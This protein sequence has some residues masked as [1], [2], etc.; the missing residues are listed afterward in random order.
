MHID[1]R[2]EG[3]LTINGRCVDDKKRIMCIHNDEYEELVFLNTTEIEDKTYMISLRV[4]YC[5]LCG[6]SYQPDSSKRE[7]F[8]N[9]EK[10]IR[11]RLDYPHKIKPQ[12]VPLGK[13]RCSDLGG[14]VKS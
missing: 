6:F 11:N 4:D 1:K 2:Q 5:P 10:L 9:D 12:S 14:D 8:P 3:V 13:M 7:D